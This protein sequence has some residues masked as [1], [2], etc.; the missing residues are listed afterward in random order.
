MDRRKKAITIIE[1]LQQVPGV[2]LKDAAKQLG[3]KFASGASVK[4][5]PSGDEVI[6]IQGDCSYEL[7]D[8]LIEFFPELKR[9]KVYVKV[10]GKARPA[11]DR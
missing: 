3:K 9:D 6:E 7:P 1:G 8:V 2:K 5:A 10:D 11:F 4:N